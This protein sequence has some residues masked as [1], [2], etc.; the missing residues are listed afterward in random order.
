VVDKHSTGES[1]EMLI[2]L[3]GSGELRV[4]GQD[5]LPIAPGRVLYNPPH[6]VHAVVNT[7][8]EALV[9]IYVVAGIRGW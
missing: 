2:P 8:S 5:P 9:Y 4:P 3:S 1:E 6:T 7:G